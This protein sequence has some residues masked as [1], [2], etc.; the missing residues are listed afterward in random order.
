MSKALFL[1]KLKNLFFFLIFKELSI[2]ITGAI[3]SLFFKALS[4][5]F[6]SF[7]EKNGLAA[8]WINTLFGLNFFKNFKAIKDESCLVLPPFIN[9][10]FLFFIFLKYLLWDLF[11][12]TIIFLKIFDSIALSIEYF[13]TY[14]PP[15]Y[16]YC[17]GIL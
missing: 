3:A 17:F 7:K 1:S 12:T 14:L 15:T 10:I 4:I 5:D 11:T 8:S 2:F 6:K 13:K 9:V 16:E